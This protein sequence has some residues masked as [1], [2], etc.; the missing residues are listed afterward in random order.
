MCV[1][2]SVCGVCASHLVLVPFPGLNVEGH[3]DLVGVWG[4]SGHWGCWY[5]VELKGLSK[6]I[7]FIS[8]LELLPGYPLQASA[9]RYPSDPGFAGVSPSTP[10]PSPPGLCCV[11]VCVCMSV[12]DIAGRVFECM[13]VWV[14]VCVCVWRE[15]GVYVCLYVCV[16]CV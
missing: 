1:F 15:K 13:C 10:W 3:K 9:Q 7:G 11:Y 4:C 6:L 16:L 5:R 8:S 14:C 12:C 2:V